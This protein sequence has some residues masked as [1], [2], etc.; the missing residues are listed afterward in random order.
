MILASERHSCCFRSDGKENY[1]AAFSGSA[2]AGAASS[3]DSAGAVA[4]SPPLGSA[5]DE[6]QRVCRESALVIRAASKAR[7]PGYLLGAAL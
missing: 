5:S 7:L 1:S 6:V 2:E 3:F 4:P